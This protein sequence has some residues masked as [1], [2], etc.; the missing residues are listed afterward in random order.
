MDG[1]VISGPGG[2]RKFRWALP[3]RGKS[4]GVRVITFY[5]GTSLPVFLLGVFSKN[6]KINLSKAER[7]ELQRVLRSTAAAYKK[8]RDR[9]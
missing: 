5:T 1:E 4:G 2:A 6:T 7:N 8:R 3:G 9:T